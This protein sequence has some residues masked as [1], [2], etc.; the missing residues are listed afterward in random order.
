MDIHVEFYFKGPNSTPEESVS[1]V[2]I[3]DLPAIH[4]RKRRCLNLKVI[5]IA[6]TWQTVRLFNYLCYEHRTLQIRSS[7]ECSFA[8]PLLELLTGGHPEQ[9]EH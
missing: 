4:F 3:L 8:R 9:A 5:Y 6:I 7:Q 2:E 1:D